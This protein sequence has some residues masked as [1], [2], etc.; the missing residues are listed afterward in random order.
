MADEALRTAI[1][2]SFVAGG[3]LPLRENLVKK[4]GVKVDG[5]PNAAYFGHRHQ[6]TT[7]FARESRFWSLTEF[8]GIHSSSDSA[9]GMVFYI[10]GG[11]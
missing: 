6:G 9:P 1:S 5:C 3:G 2:T 8:D 11:Q 4:S 7:P 10:A